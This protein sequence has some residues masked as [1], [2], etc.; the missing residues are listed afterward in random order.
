MN[1]A[2][3]QRTVLLCHFCVL[4]T[5]HVCGLVTGVRSRMGCQKRRSSRFLV[6]LV[7]EPEFPRR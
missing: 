7:N 3:P 2:L 5:S 1:N 4:P 6:A